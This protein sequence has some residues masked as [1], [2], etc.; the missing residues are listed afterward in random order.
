MIW[1]EA[2]CAGMN[3]SDVFRALCLAECVALRSRVSL[4]HP[5]TA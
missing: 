4:A 2:C 3:R 5:L 1:D